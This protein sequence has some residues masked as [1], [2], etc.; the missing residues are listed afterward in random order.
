MSLRSP[1][2]VTISIFVN[3]IPGIR[4]G[5]MMQM[6]EQQYSRIMMK[7]YSIVDN[8]PFPDCIV[9]DLNPNSSL[10]LCLSLSYTG[11]VILTLAMLLVE[12]VTS[13]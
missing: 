8:F 11:M 4:D 10:M 5:D 2:L 12:W 7:Q 1:F 9:E 13:S 3:N 6:K